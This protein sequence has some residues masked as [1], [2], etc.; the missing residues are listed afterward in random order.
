M[1]TFLDLAGQTFGRLTA[2][3][4]VG[5]TRGSALWACRCSCGKTLN[6]NGAALRSGNTRS[7][8]CLVH[9]KGQGQINDL[10][11]RV[12][13][14]LTVLHQDGRRNG[15][16][17][18]RCLCECGQQ[19]SIRSDALTSGRT[20][21]C[22]CFLA[23]NGRLQGAKKK[24]DITGNTYGRLTVLG[25]SGRNRHGRLL[26]R[27]SCSCGC[28]ITT[29]G[30][31]LAQ[32]KTQS[33]GC[34]RLD[35]LASYFKGKFDLAGK[36]YGRLE[37]ISKAGTKGGYRRQ[38]SIWLCRCECGS[39]RE[40]DGNTLTSGKA[41]SCGC[42]PRFRDIAGLRSG[43]LTAL[44]RVG[45]ATSTGMATWMCRC[46]CGV[47]KVVT[48]GNIVGQHITSCGCA[49]FDKPML[50][51]KELREKSSAFA[52]KRRTRIA[53]SGGSFTAAEITQ[54]Y[55]KQKGRCGEPACRIKLNGKFHRDHW[56]PVALGGSSDIRNIVLLCQ[57]C[58]QRKH[59]RHPFV[60]AQMNG[61]LL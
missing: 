21:S 52:H 54:M 7:C 19:K 46:D 32:G 25:F 10:T 17:A 5:T 29:S 49:I 48:S 13:G 2:L 6:V 22:G 8:G 41:K 30:N 53:G 45:R 59:A 12:F 11:D 37:V 23:E 61:R 4:R 44:Y 18:W 47:E 43:R 26:W 55:K 28:E 50:G 33:C 14:R 34:F 51:P 36:A 1:G 60:W 16:V 38:A 31:A 57:P 40:F 56:L 20:R 58:N 9:D 24:V 35:E 39:E 42:L 15:A 27:C 3:S